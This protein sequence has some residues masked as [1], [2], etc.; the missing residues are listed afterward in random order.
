MFS[1]EICTLCLNG[2]LLCVDFVDV[3]MGF[4]L[5]IVIVTV[6]IIVLVFFSFS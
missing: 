3:I 1:W 5:V 2:T 6:L 4:F